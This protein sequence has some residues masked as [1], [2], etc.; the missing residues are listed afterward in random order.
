MEEVSLVGHLSTGQRARA[1]VTFNG[2]K[3]PQRLQ[4][5]NCALKCSQGRQTLYRLCAISI[6]TNI[7]SHCRE[8]RIVC[9]KIKRRICFSFWQQLDS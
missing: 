8:S 9:Q 2:I 6:L 1:I 4:T 7:A 3:H 5:F